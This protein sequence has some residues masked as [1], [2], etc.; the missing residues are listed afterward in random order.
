MKRERLPT[1][2]GEILKK[3][4]LTPLNLTQRQV[5]DNLG[6][7]IKVINRIAN[8]RTSVTPEMAIK[9]GAAF[10]TTPEFWLNA[11][12]AVDLYHAQKTSRKLPKCMLGK[13]S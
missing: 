5:A 1:T 8:G 10:D 9:L 3:G 12:I 7:D 11:Q 6:V 2:P 13:A 4:Y